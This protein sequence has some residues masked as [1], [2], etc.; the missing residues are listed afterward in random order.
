MT[1]CHFILNYNLSFL[2]RE[3]I[4]SFSLEFW[5]VPNP[6]LSQCQSKLP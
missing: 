2:M 3:A 6:G 5:A 4:I 1:F